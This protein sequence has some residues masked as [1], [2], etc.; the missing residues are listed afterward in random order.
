MKLLDTFKRIRGAPLLAGAVGI[1]FLLMLLSGGAETASDLTYTEDAYVR[2]LEHRIAQMAEAL[3][4]VSDVQVLLTLEASEDD[5]SAVP[6]TSFFSGAG[7]QSS[8]AHR[9]KVCGVA[10]VC[11]GG[12]DPNTQLSL[13]SMLSAAL[14]LP[15]SRIYVGGSG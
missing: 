15:A 9:P 11:K 1:G 2:E 13:I 12:G 10:L 6:A 8:A 5:T 14:R 4:G 7:G 3:P